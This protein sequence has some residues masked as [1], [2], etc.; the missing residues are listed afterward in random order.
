MILKNVLPGQKIQMKKSFVIH[1]AQI[2]IP[3]VL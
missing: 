1:I 2:E 3:S